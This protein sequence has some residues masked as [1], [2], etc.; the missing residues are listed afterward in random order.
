MTSFASSTTSQVV[1]TDQS[2]TWT[3]TLPFH[4]ILHYSTSEPAAPAGD[5]LYQSEIDLFQYTNKLY[6]NVI[7]R[8]DPQTYPVS[9][10][11][12]VNQWKAN[13]AALIKDII[14]ASKKF[15]CCILVSNGSSTN[16]SDRK[17][18]CSNYRN[19]SVRA[20]QQSIDV[21]A[22]PRKL[23]KVHLL[24]DFDDYSFFLR[25]GM[26]FATHTGHMRNQKIQDSIPRGS[27]AKKK[28]KKE[29]VKDAEEPESSKKKS[30]PQVVDTTSR[31]N[32]YLNYD[33]LLGNA[34]NEVEVNSHT[35]APSSVLPNTI[36]LSNLLN[37]NAATAT[38]ANYSQFL[39]DATNAA[40]QA[41]FTAP[42]FTFPH[43]SLTNQNLTM[44]QP[45]QNTNTLDYLNQIQVPQQPTP[46]ANNPTTLNAAA[47]NAISQAN[48][49]T[50]DVFSNPLIAAA[51]NTLTSG[52]YNSSPSA[53]AAAALDLFSQFTNNQGGPSSA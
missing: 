19:R 33:D 15:G 3:A 9:T 47:L 2:T 23:C 17:L 8:F 42:S 34:N 14:G 6:K 28:P 18:C 31:L 36:P 1:T 29:V 51:L 38:A 44:Q 43:S 39:T 45:T 26:G 12:D 52:N 49:S 32:K 21:N 37:S 40:A 25:C 30:P 35:Y 11:P 7:I 22:P 27:R 46:P 24:L 4:G 20:K 5:K 48:F 41:A 50:T 13:G 53:A 16:K 10:G